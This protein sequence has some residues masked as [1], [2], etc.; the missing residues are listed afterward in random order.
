[1]G[2]TVRCGLA[3]FAND[4]VHQVLGNE[5]S[6]AVVILQA[7]GIAAA[8]SQIGF[9]W[10][11]YCRALDDTRP[12]GVATVVQSVTF[13]CT[14]PLFYIF[15]VEGYAMSVLITTLSALVVR[16]AYLTRIFHGFAIVPHTLRA[17]LPCLPPPSPCSSFASPRGT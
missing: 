10:T 16:G 5:W 7:T 3:L 14:I 12:I 9:N 1:M 6:G 2:P 8:I 15:G 17:V 13:V 4:L 11:A